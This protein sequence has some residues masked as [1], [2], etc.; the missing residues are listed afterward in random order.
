[1]GGTI[2]VVLKWDRCF[3]NL[4]DFGVTVNPMS[5]LDRYQNAKLEDLFVKLTNEK[6]FSMLDHSHAYKN[7][8]LERESKKC[9]HQY[10][11]IRVSLF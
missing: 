4:C 3:P 10:M 6:Q 11:L 9:G 1:M 8:T 2:F 7:I 5:K